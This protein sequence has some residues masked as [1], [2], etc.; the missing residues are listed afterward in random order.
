MME[1]VLQE[2]SYEYRPGL[3]SGSNCVWSKYSAPVTNPK[4]AQGIRQAR[5]GG[6]LDRKATAIK[7]ATPLP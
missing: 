5:F 2:T 7:P 4:Q 6:E 3:A 1:P